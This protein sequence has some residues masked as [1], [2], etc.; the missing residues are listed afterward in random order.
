MSAVAV[1][2]IL[3]EGR[4]GQ[5]VILG[6]YQFVDGYTIVRAD[7]ASIGGLVKYLGRCYKAYPEN[8]EALKT[9]QKIDHGRKIGGESNVQKSLE[10]GSPEK[11][12]GDVLTR[13]GGSEKVSSDNGG[14]TAPNTGGDPRIRTTGD[15][16][17]NSG[18]AEAI[19]KLDPKN[20]EHWT[21]NRRPRI[22]ALVAMTGTPDITRAQID[23]AVPGF[24]RP[25]E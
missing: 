23:N 17:K 12:S 21:A 16:H 20:D 13:D 18:I 1:K 7:E 2:L 25:A 14:G 8:S 9:Q 10:Q 19:G 3:T 5:T 22:D 4:A 11:V 15:G 6:N 24:L